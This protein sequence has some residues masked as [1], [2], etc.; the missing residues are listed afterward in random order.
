MSLF[1]PN[2][3]LLI[4][5]LQRVENTRHQDKHRALHVACGSRWSQ[6]KRSMI[7]VR[8]NMSNFK[9]SRGAGSTMFEPRHGRLCFCP[10]APNHVALAAYLSGVCTQL[11]SS[12]GCRARP[13]TVRYACIRA[14]PEQYCMS[15]GG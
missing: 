7:S 13:I 8:D 6:D 15:A 11:G 2:F 10:S 5:I 12:S 9:F 3:S 1:L 14:S 4:H